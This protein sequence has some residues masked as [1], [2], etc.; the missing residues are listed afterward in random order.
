MFLERQW[1]ELAASNRYDEA[2]KLYFDFLEIAS[3]Y[4]YAKALEV[5]N[6]KE[7]Q[8][9]EINNIIEYGFQL[10]LPP[11]SPNIGA[12]CIKQLMERFPVPKTPVQYID[13]VGVLRT[14]R[15]NVL[16]GSLYMVLLEKIGDDWGAT[17]LPKRQHHGI[18]GKLTE[19]DKSSLPWR[20]QA[21]KIFGESEVRLLMSVA[22]PEFVAQ[23][24]GT[25]NSPAAC[26]DIAWSVLTADQPTNIRSM[27]DY[28]KHSQIPSRATEYCRHILEMSGTRIV[29]GGRNE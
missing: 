10:W 7:K 17:S 15:D 4:M 5:L 6:T 26:L 12:E 1:K 20:D 21:F 27:L 29:E 2:I 28:L 9:Q 25:A 19:A 13:D 24:I 23:L 18:P 8:I 3:P 11:N 16:I 14:T 22:P